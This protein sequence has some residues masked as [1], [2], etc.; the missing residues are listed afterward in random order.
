MPYIFCA[1]GEAEGNNT[2][3]RHNLFLII[4]QKRKQHIFNASSEAWG[5]FPMHNKHF[6]LKNI[7]NVSNML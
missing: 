5:I 1:R 4:Q 3:H 6:F 2:H 7:L